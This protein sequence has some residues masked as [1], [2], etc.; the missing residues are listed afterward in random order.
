MENYLRAVARGGLRGLEPPQ[1][2]A[3]QLILS[4]PGGQIIPTTVLRAPPRFQTFRRACRTSHQYFVHMWSKINVLPFTSIR[5]FSFFSIKSWPSTHNSC[6]ILIVRTWWFSILTV[7]Q[8]C[9]KVKNIWGASSNRWV[10]TAAIVLSDIFSLNLTLWSKGFDSYFRRKFYLGHFE[11]LLDFIFC[12][13][14]R[15][16][17]TESPIWA[18]DNWELRTLFIG[19]AADSS[20]QPSER[21]HS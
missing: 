3:E 5:L 17:W 1:F 11:V 6:S 15:A 9:R 13:D 18:F 14:G 19:P 16:F 4:Q 12:L 20:L 2:L 7:V 21:P 10:I 8:W